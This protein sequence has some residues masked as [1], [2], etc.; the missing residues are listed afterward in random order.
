MASRPENIGIKAI[1][2]YFPSQVCLKSEDAAV[3]T[4]PGGDNRG[5]KKH[6]YTHPHPTHHTTPHHSP[7]SPKSHSQSTKSPVVPSSRRSLMRTRYSTI[8][9]HDQFPISLFSLLSLSFGVWW[10]QFLIFLAKSREL[11]LTDMRLPPF[12]MSSNLSLKLSMAS[13]QASTL[14]VLARLRWPFA[15]TARVSQHAILCRSRSSILT[16]L[17]CVLQISTLS[18]SPSPPT[19]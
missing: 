4:A 1:E 3:A 14:L 10:L 15:M 2:I 8:I 11:P 7:S 17:V 5:Q 19:C 16:L 6:T 9:T 18:P 13:A 12:S